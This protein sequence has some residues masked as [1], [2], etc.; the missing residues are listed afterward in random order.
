LGPLPASLEP[1]AYRLLR[2]MGFDGVGVT[3]AVGMTAILE[4]W[5]LPEAAVRGLVAG[6][7]LILATP[8]TQAAAMRDAIVAAVEAGRLP[9]ARLDEAVRRVVGLQGGDPATLVCG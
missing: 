6:A 4:R 1:A 8:A 7:D 5:S 3:D 2:S 9:A